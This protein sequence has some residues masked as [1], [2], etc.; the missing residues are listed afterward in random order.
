MTARADILRAVDVLR[1]GGVVAMPTETVYGLAA[2]ARNADAVARVFA[3]KGRPADHPLIVHIGAAAQMADWARDI[4]ES[5]WRLAEA[6]WPGALTLVLPRAP[7]VCDAVTGGL[8]TV[9]LRVPNHPLALELLAAFGSGVAA[10]SAN[11][12]GHVSPTSAEHVRDELGDAVD[13]IL[14]GGLCGIGLESTIVD[15]ASHVPRILRPGAVTEPMLARVLGAQVRMTQDPRAHAPGRKPSHYAPRAR[16]VLVADDN[17]AADAIDRCLRQGFRVGVLASRAPRA[18]PQAVAWL[19][20]PHEMD[21]QARELYTQLRAADHL[22]L[23]VL[24]A[25]PPPVG[26]GLAEAIRD[27]LTRAAGPRSNIRA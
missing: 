6:F 11:R 7:G 1:R 5:A 21:A 9:A 22:G 27:R 17:E 15:L 2:D 24:I 3:I 23:D 12:Y 16:V 25:I 8:D 13:F 4:P 10:P 26:D 18:L 14:D 20:L 19:E